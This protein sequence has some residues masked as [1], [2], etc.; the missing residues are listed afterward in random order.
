[1]SRKNRFRK[2]A[3][4]S[5]RDLLKWGFTLGLWGLCALLVICIYYSFNLPEIKEVTEFKK[6]P[7]IIIY[8]SSNRVIAR[9]GDLKGQAVKVETLPPN[10]VNAVLAIEDRRFYDHFG[11]DPR[12]FARAMLTNLVEGQFV[13]GGSTITQ[14]L[15]KNV[16]LTADKKVSRKIQEA[17][18]ALWLERNFTK[19]QILNAYLNRVYLGAGAYGMD[20]AARIYFD[21]P[22]AKVD[23]QEAAIL[24]GL[25]KAPSRYSPATNPDLAVKRGQ[26][27]LQAMLE[28]G[29]IN[30]KQSHALDDFQ[31]ISYNKPQTT[32]NVRYFTDWVVDQMDDY[33]GTTENDLNVHTTLSID[34]QK[35][36]ESAIE[37]R[38]GPVSEERKIGQAA[39]VSMSLDGAIRV[40]TGGRSYAQSQF[41]RA[42]QAKRQPGSAFKPFV[43]LAALETGLEPYTKVLDAPI[44]I[45]N[46][47]PDNYESG[48][49]GE[50]TLALALAKS[51]NT[52]TVRVMQHTGVSPVI[53]LARRLGVT[54]DLRPDMSLALGSSEMTLMELTAA[55][56]G[57]ANGGYAIWPYAIEKI[58]DDNGHVY[59]QR[60]TAMYTQVVNETAVKN[61]TGMMKGVIDFGTGRNAALDGRDAAGKTGTSQ[62][63]RDAW[64]MGFTSDL[65]A[66]VWIG[67]D[68][69][70]PMKGVTGGSFPALI[71]HDYM[72]YAG[73]IQQPKRWSFTGRA[74][75]SM[76]STLDSSGGSF[77]DLLKRMTGRD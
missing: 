49:E 35:K 28:A 39:F 29:Y 57:I 42:V 60:E 5:F 62:D 72:V 53:A 61:L 2:H 27:V 54:S 22:A 65:V 44:E 17:I 7:T 13:Q 18:L 75:G 66:G 3:A 38:L 4:S 32:E 23:L 41:N 16:F 8:D 24:A 47:S 14:Q 67:N 10:L 12:G 63:F 30:E 37:A 31:L 1:M 45:G 55:Y 71:W 46:Y 25:L 6:K 74:A 59:Y 36:A 70:S 9:Y 11:L 58:D 43:Y 19:D 73:Q 48:Y 77:S 34:L 20:A 64:F 56:A 50:V 15:A 69:N 40:M 21:K 52:A 68:D 33:I 51:L 26:M 76:P